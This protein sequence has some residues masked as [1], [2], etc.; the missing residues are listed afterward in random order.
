MPSYRPPGFGPV[1]TLKP[2]E[3]ELRKEIRALK[4]LVLNRCEFMNWNRAVSY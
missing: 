4:G 3:E 1:A 2:E